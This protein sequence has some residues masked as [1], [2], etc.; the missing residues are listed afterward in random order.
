MSTIRAV[1]IFTPEDC[2]A[3]TCDCEPGHC[4]FPLCVDCEAP[5]LDG[6]TNLC[7][8]CEERHLTGEPL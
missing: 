5:L 4:M 7:R 3:H 1:Q 8:E 6:E 2:K